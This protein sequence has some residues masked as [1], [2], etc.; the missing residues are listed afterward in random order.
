M[1]DKKKLIVDEIDALKHL[2]SQKP[3]SDLWS[4]S[5]KMTKPLRTGILPPV[6]E[7]S[8]FQPHNVIGA[9]GIGGKS[10]SIYYQSGDTFS[11]V[12]TDHDHKNNIG[13]SKPRTHSDYH[14]TNTGK[15][16]VSQEFYKG[17][18][19]H[20]SRN[21]FVSVKTEQEQQRLHTE[22]SKFPDLKSKYGK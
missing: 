17:G 15:D 16:G 3:G 5:A 1:S 11:H 8:L 2:R 21:P 4:R 9:T 13:R 6:P 18:L 22:A 10:P 19:Q 12:T 20:T 7:K 14:I